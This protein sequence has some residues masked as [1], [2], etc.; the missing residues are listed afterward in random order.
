MKPESPQETPDRNVQLLERIDQ[1]RAELR[2]ADPD[3]LARRAGC[4]FTPGQNPVG[5]LHLTLWGR[6]VRLCVPDWDAV[7]VQG[8]EPPHTANLALLIYYFHTV[9]AARDRVQQEAAGWISFSDLPDG[10]FYTQAFQ[11]YTGALLGRRFGNR[12]ENFEAAA[13]GCGGTQFVLG[14]AA[15]SFEV[16]PRVTLAAVCWLGDEDFPASYRI[17]FSETIADYLPTDA[18][19]I[20][21]SMLT[22]R[23]ISQI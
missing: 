21:G 14:D 1:L 22:Q 18:C 5:D 17:L 2:D 23:I 13:L 4:T 8:V 6:E 15:F 19:A 10:R 16:L 3:A 9:W 7:Y 20:A 12:K 11:G